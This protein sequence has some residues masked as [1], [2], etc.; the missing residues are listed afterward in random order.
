[1]GRC[2]TTSQEGQ[3]AGRIHHREYTGVVSSVIARWEWSMSLTE[4]LAVQ[5]SGSAVSV[6][7][8]WN[9]E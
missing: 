9:G 5:R 3:S 6:G 7:A 8:V 1:M 4:T 2:G